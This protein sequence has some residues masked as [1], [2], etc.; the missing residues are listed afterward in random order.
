M[1]IFNFDNSHLLGRVREVDTR[2]VSIHVKNDEDLAKAQVGQLIA[3]EYASAVDA[4]L[5]AIIDKV[6][7]SVVIQREPENNEVEPYEQSINE[8]IVVNTVKV[9]LLGTVK[10]DAIK[11]KNIF[12]RS[13]NR[14]PCINAILL[15]F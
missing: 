11:S 10:W 3:I 7:K 2:R 13:L 15:R 9:T 14:V 6:I 8:E 5:I 12:T 1:A 4:W